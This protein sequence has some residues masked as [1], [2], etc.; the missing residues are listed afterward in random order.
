MHMGDITAD[1]INQNLYQ[2]V[3]GRT[4]DAEG[5]AYWTA[6]AAKQ[7]WTEQQLANVWMD[8]AKTVLQQSSAEMRAALAPAIFDAPAPAPVS[9]ANTTAL[10]V[11]SYVPQQTLPVVGS[12]LPAVD[13][14]LQTLTQGATQQTL[15]PAAP[16]AAGD[17]KSKML[18]WGA[19]AL[20]GFLL[21]KKA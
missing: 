19:L 5:V 20:G 2:D 21:L 3:L 7:G 10:P 16:A 9:A 4:G 6:E 15:L 8:S 1:W 18:M 12:A 13:R 14:V 17:D 11:Q